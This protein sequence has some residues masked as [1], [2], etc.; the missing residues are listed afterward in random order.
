[1]TIESLTDL[2]RRIDQGVKDAV[3]LAIEDHRRLGQ[4][5]VVWRDGRV[6][7]VPPEE[8]PPM[9]PAQRER[10]LAETYQGGH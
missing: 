7:I 2:R 6:V 9:D 4:S 1:M 10:L 5:I 8:I 3:A